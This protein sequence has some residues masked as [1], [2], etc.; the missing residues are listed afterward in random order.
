M[1]AYEQ[2][3][4]TPDNLIDLVDEALAAGV[5]EKK[6]ASL[7]LTDP[8]NWLDAEGEDRSNIFLKNA[9]DPLDILFCA[10]D[11]TDDDKYL[12]PLV[13]VVAQWCD[14]FNSLDISSQ[15][16]A[17]EF[18]E[19]LVWYDM[20]AG[21]RVYRL[22]YLID[23][24]TQRGS[25]ADQRAMMQANFTLHHTY[26]ADDANF[27]QN[28]HG[29]Y[30]SFGQIAAG[31][32]LAKLGVSGA[33][34]MEA[35]GRHRFAGILK[36]QF[37]D[38]GIHLE[39][40]PGYQSATTQILRNL[41]LTGLIEDPHVLLLIERLIDNTKWFSVPGGQPVNF[42]DTDHRDAKL[43]V[44]LP[45]APG[46]V[47][48]ATFPEGGYFVLRARPDTH[49]ASKK[50][51]DD[52]RLGYLAL[53]AAF[54]SRTHKHCDDGSFV[55]YHEGQP[56][57]IDGGRFGYGGKQPY[58]SPLWHD[59]YWYAAPE[60]VYLERARAHNTI[61]VDNRNMPRRKLTPTGSGILGSGTT[62]VTLSSGLTD[63]G[64]TGADAYF[65]ECTNAALA[66]RI[67]QTANGLPYTP[68]KHLRLLI[69]LP[70]AWIVCI[71]TTKAKEPITTRQWFNLAN[72]FHLARWTP[73]AAVMHDA[74]TDMHVTLASL[75]GDAGPLE[76]GHG[77]SSDAEDGIYPD[78][79]GWHSKAAGSFNKNTAL[80][81]GSI[82][83]RTSGTIATLIAP[84]QV[85]VDTAYTRINASARR[86][87]FSFDVN[88]RTYTLSYNRED[89][90]AGT[91]VN[92]Q[93]APIKIR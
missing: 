7:S 86:G 77:W 23:V 30:Q 22:A 14:T 43:K 20:A 50:T 92:I 37:A 52:A 47:Q 42:G 67:P 17:S 55:W 62:P 44:V 91:Q 66:A 39:H 9:W 54:H 60:R 73:Q 6:K 5:I 36:G 57:L 61:E 85:R 75:T 90:E 80:A 49:K 41:T 35:Q 12:A 19:D 34:E 38:E 13:R 63:T 51:T 40:S 45:I 46:E 58:E 78:I 11:K 71:D 16:A 74:D 93:A 87:R 10:F 70:N 82:A 28:N 89:E 1:R 59:G 29:L 26:L 56:V 25:H 33:S 64:G 72:R 65:V 68:T 2:L 79:L 3:Y 21:L 32:R 15:L 53:M 84:G 8:R 31:S 69:T 76:M 88:G 18:T 27:R 24:L 83:Q 81:I 48:T 4:R